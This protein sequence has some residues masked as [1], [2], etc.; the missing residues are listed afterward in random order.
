[1][2]N[3]DSLSFDMCTLESFQESLFFL[4]TESGLR[5]HFFP[6]NGVNS[7]RWNSSVVGT[8]TVVVLVLVLA[9]STGNDWHW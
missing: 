6:K 1:M 7:Q 3:C 2:A 8:S 9:A 5:S 4:K